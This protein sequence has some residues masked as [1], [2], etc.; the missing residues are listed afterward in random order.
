[1]TAARSAPPRLVG[2]LS[3]NTELGAFLGD[4]RI[5]LLEAIGRHGSISRAAKV[6]PMSYKAAWDA[7]G[8]MNNLA[9]SPL[10]ESS[11]GG[12]HGGGTHLTDYGR[13]LVGLYRAVEEEYR[14]AV[15]RLA[16][17]MDAAETGDQ[18]E[19]QS[20]LKRMSMRT[21]ARNQLVGT[22]IELRK[23]E[24]SAE[25]VMSLDDRTRVVAI[26]TRDSAEALGLGPGMEVHALVK[27]SS[28]LLS[29]DPG[30]KTS[31]RNQIW[32]QVSRIH[33][34]PV[35]AEVALILPGGRTL[36]AMITPTGLS[37]LDLL[38]GRA[39]CAVFQASSVILAT[40]V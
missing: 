11:V 21:S 19:F 32:G 4:T 38:P 31:A 3:V 36:T 12:R 6:V 14:G 15:D 37:K 23:D 26:V 20:L 30:L 35:D 1:M 9:D 29:T 34:G 17:G 40:F 33:E 27:A 16:R 24:V 5:R 18:Q 39:V 13:R 7:L 28:V 8:A 2:K 10:V 25:A 22:L